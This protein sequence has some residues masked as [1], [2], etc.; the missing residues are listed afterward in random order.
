MKKTKDE[1]RERVQLWV[2]YYRRKYP[3][4]SQEKIMRL[5]NLHPWLSVPDNS[6]DI[7]ASV[8]LPGGDTITFR[9]PHC[10]A[11]IELRLE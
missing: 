10:G 4:Y 6:Q 11:V 7:A 1:R 9:C 5:A 8:E 3:I 2:D